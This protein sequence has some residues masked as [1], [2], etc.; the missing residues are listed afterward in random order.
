MRGVSLTLCLL[1]ATAAPALAVVPFYSNFGGLSDPSAIGLSTGT[2]AGNGAA[3]PP[4][5]SWSEVANDSPVT[6]NASVGFAGHRVTSP[7]NG[8]W[9]LADD[10]EVLSD[11]LFDLDQVRLFAY[12]TDAPPGASPFSGANL[13]IWRGRP[14]DMNAELVFG[15]VSTNRLV[16][17]ND[18]GIYR[19]SNS[20]VD[21]DGPGGPG[22]PD[23]RRL[24]RELVLSA[25]VTLGPGH[26][27]LDF[28]V[29]M[30]LA[31]QSG[32]FPAITIPGTRSRPG[33]NARQFTNGSTIPPAPPGWQDV[34]DAGLAATGQ[35]T[36]PVVSQDLPFML[37][38]TYIPEPAAGLL[39]ALTG[40]FIRRR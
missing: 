15:D 4:G 23:T 28:Q 7:A 12:R 9:R 20:V 2:T 31:S 37:D 29:M 25:D 34:L 22:V 10:F 26:Y 19:I 18:T 1:L 40:L 11:E 3:A 35:P 5:F 27:W 24:V 6:A 21:P 8:G 32:F 33:W 13:R 30:P 17:T 16:A 39:A 36:P 14:G 38:G